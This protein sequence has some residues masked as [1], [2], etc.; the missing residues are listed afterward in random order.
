MS[1]SRLPLTGQEYIESLKDNREVWINGER[2]D[3]VTTHTA[4]RNSVRSIARMYD[5]LHDEK[6]KSILTRDTDTGNGGF[7]QRF[8]STDKTK[9][10]LVAT[11]DAIAEWAKLTY[12]PVGR[13]TDE[14]AAIMGR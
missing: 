3:D 7:A 4:F 2:V 6:T 10:D 14:K 11:R 12:G 8:F 5:A 1:V 13:A 9:E